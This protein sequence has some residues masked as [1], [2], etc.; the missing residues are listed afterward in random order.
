MNANIVMSEKGLKE[1]LQDLNGL[2]Y[3][4]NSFITGSTDPEMLKLQHNMAQ[5]NLVLMQLSRL[6]MYLIEKL[7]DDEK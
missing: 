2:C 5:L 1:H 3:L 4:P 7:E 6:C